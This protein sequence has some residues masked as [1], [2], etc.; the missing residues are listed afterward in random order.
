M[1]AK[2]LVKK[3]GNNLLGKKVNT[4]ALGEYPGGLATVTQ[5]APD[6]NAPEIAFQIN[7]AQWGQTGVFGHEDVSVLSDGLGVIHL[8]ENWRN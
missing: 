7:L 3:L 8:H 2:E 1:K 5:I 6:K 4:P